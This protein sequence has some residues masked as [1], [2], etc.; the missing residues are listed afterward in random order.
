MPK[1]D[2]NT[3]KRLIAMLD[4]GCSASSA[5]KALGLKRG[6]IYFKM[7]PQQRQQFDYAKAANMHVYAAATRHKPESVKQME[8]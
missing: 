3:F 2:E 1:L 4:D 5:A 7:S 6:E 8:Q